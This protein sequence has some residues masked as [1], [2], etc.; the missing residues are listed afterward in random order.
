MPCNAGRI[1]NKHR[2]NK[3]KKDK[4]MERT[5]KIPDWD[6]LWKDEESR[7]DYVAAA[8]MNE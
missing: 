5:N 8:K 4:Q 3:K 1:E 2:Q 6:K 7:Q